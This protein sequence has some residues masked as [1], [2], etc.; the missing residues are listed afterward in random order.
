MNEHVE[1]KEVYFFGLGVGRVVE[2]VV[3]A[4]IFINCVKCNRKLETMGQRCR[5][6]CS[7]CIML[8]E[9]S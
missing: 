3:N 7:F 9:D 4:P 5:G 8:P 2:E 1:R 6:R